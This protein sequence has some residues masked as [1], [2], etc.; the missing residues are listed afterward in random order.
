MACIDRFIFW[1]TTHGHTGDMN[2]D[3]KEP[4]ELLLVES[5]S[6]ARNVR[7]VRF[8]DSEVSGHI[9]INL[10]PVAIVTIWCCL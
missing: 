5:A 3:V 10:H 6:T 8:K 2:H 9:Q 4:G 1:D 7:T